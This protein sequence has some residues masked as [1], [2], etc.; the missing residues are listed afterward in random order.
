[1]YRGRQHQD[2]RAGKK[3]ERSR[4][5]ARAKNAQTPDEEEL[6]KERSR[7]CAESVPAV[8]NSESAGVIVAGGPK[9]TNAGW[10]CGAHQRRWDDEQRKR[11]DESKEV[12]RQGTVQHSPSPQQGREQMRHLRQQQHQRD[13]REHDSHLQHGEQTERIPLRPGPRSRQVS[14]RDPGHET[15]QHNGC[16]PGGVA[17][18]QARETEPQGLEQQPGRSREKEGAGE[19]QSSFQNNLA[20][21]A[22]TAVS[23]LK[24]LGP[25]LTARN[26]I[27]WS[28][29]ISSA[30][31]PPSGPTTRVTA[32]FTSRGHWL[33][34]PGCATSA[35]EFFAIAGSSSST[36]GRKRRR[37]STT[38][39][40]VSRACSRPRMHCARMLSS[41]RRG[42]SQ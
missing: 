9:R 32:C 38:G 42:D 33:D 40:T 17:E 37:R 30:M 19:A 6:S 13:A 4:D 3:I 18:C 29:A 41:E 27:F 8:Q 5:H 25:K 28:D 10:Q 35:M 34:A 21:S 12:E 14:H 11:E 1:M 7:H 31:N 26:P 22:A 2:D 16:R 23:T 24:I 20:T 36:N 39:I 15:R